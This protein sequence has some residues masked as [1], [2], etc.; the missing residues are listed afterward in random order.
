MEGE[1]ATTSI[2]AAKEIRL[3]AALAAVFLEQDG[4]KRRTNNATEGFPR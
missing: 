1:E 2:A 3:D 4:I